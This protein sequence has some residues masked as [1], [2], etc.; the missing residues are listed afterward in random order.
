MGTMSVMFTSLPSLYDNATV[1]LSGSTGLPGG[2]SAVFSGSPV[3][4]TASLA[5][6][7]LLSIDVSTT[8]SIPRLL[9]I[10]MAFGL[11]ICVLV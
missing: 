2:G 1:G 6:T 10:S 3:N 11:M 9:T 8:Y 7:N 4:S 5:G